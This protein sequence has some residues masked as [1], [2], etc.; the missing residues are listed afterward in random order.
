MRTLKLMLRP[1]TQSPAPTANLTGERGIDKLNPDTLQLSLVGD[2]RLQLGIRP[3]MSFVVQ[4]VTF[5]LLFLSVV[6]QPFKANHGDALLKWTAESIMLQSLP[7]I[8]FLVA[9]E[10]STRGMSLENTR[11]NNRVSD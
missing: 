9:S 3:T 6:L 8:S 1:T 5:I 11:E 4:S 10:L 2:E 7:L